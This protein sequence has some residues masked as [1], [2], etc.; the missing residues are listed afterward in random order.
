MTSRENFK[1]RT[2]IR[3]TIRKI[4]DEYVVYPKRGGKRLGTHKTKAAA[5]KQLT[6]IHLNREAIE[7][8][9]PF[10]I[11]DKQ[12]D[13]EDNSL[14]SVDYTFD[15]PTKTYRV[16]LNS[17][18]YG[19]EDKIFD[20]SFG[21]DKGDFNKIDTFQMTGE[22]SVG[23]IIYTI[24]KIIEDFINKFDV[25][26]IK[27]SA[28]TEKRQRVYKALFSK[29]PSSL[30]DKVEI[31][32][33]IKPADPSEVDQ[34]ELKMGIKVE[35]EHTDDPEEAK[36]IALQHLA[37]DPKY[38]TKLK[39]VGLE[40]L[41]YPNWLRFQ[42][43]TPGNF[44]DG[45]HRFRLPKKKK[46]KETAG[47]MT[48]AEKAKHEKNMLRLRKILN[49]Q[50]NSYIPYPDI[51]NTL[52]RKLHDKSLPE[53]SYEGNMGFEEMFKFYQQATEKQVE[54]LEKLIDEDKIKEAWQLVQKVVGVKLKGKEFNEQ[55]ESNQPTVASLAKQHNRTEST[56]RIALKRGIEKELTY[57][58][59]VLSARQIALDN[60]YDDPDYYAKISQLNV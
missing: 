45:E 31:N 60:L 48:A 23:K 59:D 27:A 2:F 11:D 15:T 17:G 57:V 46:I 1:L 41:N 55:N 22:G 35:M 10:Q 33:I 4:G 43:Q 20:L 30:S 32:E 16:V 21:V 7:E 56:I 39:K 26:K 58:N 12:F 42:A 54:L 49:K 13:E 5:E 38:Y 9:F 44:P 51:P 3:E 29:L 52:Q 28:T 19:P 18:E 6:A 24:I 40:M 34:K 47:I 14:I 50:P 37:E 36:I 25:N 53:A 8:T